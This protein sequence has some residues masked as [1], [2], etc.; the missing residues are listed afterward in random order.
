MKKTEN[1]GKKIEKLQTT[2][3]QIVN[4][5]ASPE[6]LLLRTVILSRHSDNNRKWSEK[7]SIRKMGSCASK[8]TNHPIR[9]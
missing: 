5:S 3:V 7:Q 8:L 2:V 4:E 1:L 6:G 9:E